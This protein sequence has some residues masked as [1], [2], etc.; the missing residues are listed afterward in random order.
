MPLGDIIRDMSA[1]TVSK[2]YSIT[3]VTDNPINDVILSPVAVCVPS[4][5][6]SI[7]ASASIS[8]AVGVK[9]E[10][11]LSTSQDVS[12][13]PLPAIVV[14][15]PL[16]PVHIQRTDA[17]SAGGRIFTT[18][19]VYIDDLTCQYSKSLSFDGHL[20]AQRIYIRL[21][22]SFQICCR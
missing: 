7:Q 6:T 11:V 2:V 21:V 18:P 17:Q 4:V 5:S 19:K 12:T 3:I 13:S 15:K 22:V 14:S 8:A 16:S 1:L 9:T 20:Y 10:L